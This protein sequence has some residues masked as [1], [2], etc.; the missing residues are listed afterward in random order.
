M[1]SIALLNDL[2]HF[3]TKRLHFTLISFNHES[4][5]T[6]RFRNHYDR[7]GMP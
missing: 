4:E 3:L 2:T 7:S 6:F 5:K 1:K